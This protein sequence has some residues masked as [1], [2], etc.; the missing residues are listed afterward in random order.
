MCSLSFVNKG[1][2]DIFISKIFQMKDAID[3]LSINL[4]D[5]ED[6]PVIPYKLTAT[7]KNKVFN[8]KK[9]NSKMNRNIEG[10]SLNDNFYP[11]NWKR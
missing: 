5:Q 11:S 6:I 3:S 9:K 4:Q 2:A 1:M 10:Q 7:I 8:H